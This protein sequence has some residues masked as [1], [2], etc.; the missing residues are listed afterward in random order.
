MTPT[1]TPPHVP[2][3]QFRLENGLRVVMSPDTSVPVVSVAVYYDVGSRN[4][5][6][7][8]TGFAHLFV[9][10]IFQGFENVHKAGH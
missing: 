5:R 3:E 10:M 7:G 2:V 1:P 6:E 8:C 4:E 9:H